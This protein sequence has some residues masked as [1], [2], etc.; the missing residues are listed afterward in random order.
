MLQG[1]LLVCHAS[2][3]PFKR[4]HTRDTE[5][6]QARTR[7]SERVSAAAAWAQVLRRY[8]LASLLAELLTKRVQP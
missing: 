8:A 6:P 7:I 4:S 2:L 5:R 1:A 3:R